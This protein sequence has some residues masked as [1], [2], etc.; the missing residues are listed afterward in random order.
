MSF[1]WWKLKQF[2]HFH[3][4]SENTPA[5][6]VKFSAI[7]E[8]Q[9]SLICPQTHWGYCLVCEKLR[10][11]KLS[12]VKHQESV[13]L[14]LKSA[15]LKT[16][17]STQENFFYWLDRYKKEAGFFLR[18]T[19]TWIQLL[20]IERPIVIIFENARVVSSFDSVYFGVL[21]LRGPKNLQVCLWKVLKL[22]EE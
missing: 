3:F 13:W 1:E 21:T 7:G 11:R 5:A 17:N 16:Q 19:Y 18:R 10:K 8:T 12:L 20:G 6:C 22:S 14:S 9:Y 4:M 15:H 2:F